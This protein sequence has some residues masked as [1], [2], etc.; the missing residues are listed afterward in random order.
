[1]KLSQMSKTRGGNTSLGRN[2]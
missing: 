2:S 1:M